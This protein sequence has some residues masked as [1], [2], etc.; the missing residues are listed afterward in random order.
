[1][2]L[3]LSGQDLSDVFPLLGIPGPPTPPYKLAG[4]LSREPNIWHL[5]KMSLHAGDSDLAGGIAI[6]QHSK[7][8]KL[9]ANL[10][11]Q[12]LA[13][14]DLAPLIGATPGKSGNVSA[15][16]RQTEQKLEAKSELFPD[17]PMQV[18]R[19][20]A[21][22][23]DVALYA[24][25]IMAPDYLPVTSLDL[26]VKVQDGQAMV[27]PLILGVAGGTVKGTMSVDARSDKPV[28]KA[29]LRYKDLDLAAF[30][31]GSDYVDTTHGKLEGRVALS[32]NGRSLAQVMGSADGDFV[33]GSTG[34]SI[35][36]LLVSLAGLQ[37]VDALV[38]YITGDDSIPIQCV[39]GRLVFEKGVARFD[40]T[41]LDTQKSVVHVDGSVSLPT[42][43]VDIKVTG[44]PKSFSLLDLHGPVEVQGKIRK[45]DISIGRVI[46]IPTPDFGGAKGIDCA[47]LLQSLQAASQ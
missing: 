22:N 46:P 27:D 35:S 47:S 41:I 5:D 42:Q 37:I 32:G 45:P 25:K 39:G 29:D 6:D 4:N 18:E 13:F 24:R 15:Q 28:T 34:G 9:T 38:L 16:Q 23:M 20:R 1:V 30:F 40:R 36:S 33:I 19:L 10:V 11:S 7:P 17:E 8:S 2:Q 44:D 21:M 43:A 12:R 26:R 3:A 31:R 14:A